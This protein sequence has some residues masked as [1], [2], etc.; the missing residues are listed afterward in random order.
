MGRPVLIGYMGIEE[1][2]EDWSDW[3]GVITGPANPEGAN[4]FWEKPIPMI[5]KR[6][7]DTLKAQNEI[8]L[9][10]LEAECICIPKSVYPDNRICDAHRAINAALA[11]A[12]HDNQKDGK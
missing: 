3:T 10:G 12:Q 2:A 11:V 6:A 4:L 9:K 1:Q 8:L 5:E 7:Y